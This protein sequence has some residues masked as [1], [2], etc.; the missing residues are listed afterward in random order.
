VAGLVG[1]GWLLVLGYTAH[2]LKDFWQERRAGMAR[3]AAIAGG[4]NSAG[5]AAVHLAKF[6]AQVTLL[7]R[8]GP[9][10]AGMSDY[11]ITQLKTTPNVMVRLRTAPPVRHR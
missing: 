10:A 2:G 5:Q 8:G 11:L 3:L 1:P 9:H 4:A 7:I 6:A